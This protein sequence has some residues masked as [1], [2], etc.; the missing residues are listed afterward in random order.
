MDDYLTSS[1]RGCPPMD[2]IAP[3]VRA[4]HAGQ[5]AVGERPVNP[6]QGS[7]IVAGKPGLLVWSRAA[8][9]RSKWRG[10]GQ[11]AAYRCSVG[12]R[13]GCRRVDLRGGVVQTGGPRSN[14][15]RGSHTHRSRQL[16]NDRSVKAEQRITRDKHKGV[17]NA[18]CLFHGSGRPSPAL[19]RS[20]PV[21]WRDSGFSNWA[22]VQACH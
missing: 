9:E 1:E 7:V 13:G 5:E 6:R 22:C 15:I 16:L 4:V 21:V 17:K 10:P 11:Y 2:C 12:I 14:A 19:W 20:A 8:D 18:E 3:L